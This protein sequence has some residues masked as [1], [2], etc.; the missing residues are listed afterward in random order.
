MLALTVR[1]G[2]AH[3]ARLE[4]IGDRAIW[5]ALVLLAAGEFSA[6]QLDVRPALRSSHRAARS[7]TMDKFRRDVRGAYVEDTGWN[8]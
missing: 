5:T 6:T 7:D 8:A 4:Q 1:P 2:K 3:S